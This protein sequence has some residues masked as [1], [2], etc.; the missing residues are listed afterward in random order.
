MIIN[1]DVETRRKSKMKDDDRVLVLKVMDG[2]SPRDTAGKIDPRLFSGENNLHV[3]YD[4]NTGMW[5]FRYDVGGLPEPLKQKY[6]EFQD[7]VT[8]AR[9]YF[10]KRNVQI[11]RI[12][13]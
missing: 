6:T 12:E 11:D 3:I 4:E 9:Q 7:A 1:Y 13:E 8:V 2:K 10:A 5:S